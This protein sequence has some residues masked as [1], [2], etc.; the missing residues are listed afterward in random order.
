[1]S[2]SSSDRGL[3]SR[4]SP[5]YSPIVALKQDVNLKNSIFLM[6]VKFHLENLEDQG[7]FLRKRFPKVVTRGDYLNDAF[8]TLGGLLNA[9]SFAQDYKKKR[10][11]ILWVRFYM[12]RIIRVIPLYMIVLGFYA[13]LFPYFGS[14]PLWPTY[15]THPLCKKNWWWNLL[16]INNFL[17]ARNQCMIWT[18]YL[19]NDIQFYCIVPLLMILLS[20]WPKL[21]YILAGACIGGSCLSVFWVTKT[22][23]LTIDL[24]RIAFHLSDMPGFIDRSFETFN[25][26]TEKP[27]TRTSSYLVGILLGHYLSNRKIGNFTERN[28]ILLCCGWII[29][30]LFTRICFSSFGNEE[31]LLVTFA[32][33]N[34]IRHLLFAAGLSWII[35]ACST[36]QAAFI[37]SCLSWHGFVIL[38]R[39]SYC[40]YLLNFFVVEYYF[41]RLT[42]VL[43]FS[44]AYMVTVTAYVFF[45]TFIASFMVS[46][47]I[48]IPV[49]R[50]YSMLTSKQ[51]SE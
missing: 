26:L 42:Q 48:E 47:V 19:A 32:V 24:F 28:S 40:A 25:Y 10:G 17:T 38:S 43:E 31:E 2:S 33:Y 27:Y 51:K 21:G 44:V 7:D 22:L 16:F 4:G 9:F 41:F 49:S 37:N 3:K 14:G 23:N 20:K 12:K 50:L 30:A 5:Q 1:M 35:F 13:T 11:N 18:W 39:L 34:G 29:T 15:A 45:W 36:G 6:Q 8:F 46:V